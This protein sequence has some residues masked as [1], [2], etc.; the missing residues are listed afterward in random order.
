MRLKTIRDLRIWRDKKVIVRVDANVPMHEGIVSDDFRLRAFLPTVEYLS[1]RGAV[2]I[3]IAHLGRPNGRRDKMLSLEPIAKRLA[4]ISGKIITFVPDLGGELSVNAIKAAVPGQIFLL[5]NLR[6]D[7]GE[8]SNSGSFAKRLAALGEI[9][10]NDGFGVSHR[11]HASVSAIAKLLPAYAGFLM[12]RELKILDHVRVAPASPSLAMVGGAKISTK[13]GLIKELAKRYDNI[14]V[15][16]GLFNPFLVAGG[17]GIGG[18]LCEPGAEK[19]IK[20]LLKMKKIVTPVD[21][22]V[23]RTTDPN[24]PVRVV[25]IDF[26][27][28]CII[29]KKA[30]KIVDIGPRTILSWAMKI[31]K[32]R[33]IVWNGPVGVFEISRFS[34]GTISLARMVAARSKGKALGVAGGGETVEALDRT[35]M[36]EWMDHISTGG[37]AMLEFLE[38]RVLPGVKPLYKK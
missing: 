26:D 34:H 8:E 36:A 10:V 18:S 1:A 11:A 33:T 2:V 14:L 25:P 19:M 9:F 13:I 32:A 16:G 4:Q 30:E 29:C 22:L 35:G 6:F 3:L 24:A 38:G 17:F 12:E 20:P 15:G 27:D 21:V 28:P 37:A 5:E 7:G 31:K 23:G